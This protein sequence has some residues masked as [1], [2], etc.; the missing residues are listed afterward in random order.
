[1]PERTALL[2][3]SPD[4]PE[5]GDLAPQDRPQHIVVVDGTWG[6]A[7]SLLRGTPS[8][9]ALPRF[10]LAPV[11]ES[12]YRIRKEPRAECV[13]TIEAII[14]ALQILEP[15]TQGLNELLGAFEHM[16]DKQI[17]LHASRNKPRIKRPKFARIAPVP[18]VIRLNAREL[19]LVYGEVTNQRNSKN[20]REII[21]WCALRPV[22]GEVFSRYLRPTNATVDSSHLENT[23]LELADILA[24]VTHAEFRQDWDAFLNPR[25]IVTA[26]NQSSLD[27]VE[28]PVGKLT[29]KSIYCNLCRGRSGHL[30]SVLRREGLGPL[31]QPFCGRAGLRMGQTLAVLKYLRSKA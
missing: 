25:D 22:T 12:R 17:E 21:Y 13:S 30:E 14:L 9:A 23:G 26:W 3:P 2:Y 4:V 6:H 1:M 16:I 19:V 10:R 20:G 27:L 24:G 18:E 15:E 8:L 31:E 29:L 7:H 11:V 5:L 28:Q